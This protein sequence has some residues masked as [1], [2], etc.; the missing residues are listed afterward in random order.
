[1]AD[2]KSCHCNCASCEHCARH[3]KLG[4]AA[5]GLIATAAAGAAL[6]VYVIRPWHLRWQPTPD[7]AAGPMQ[8]DNLVADPT[9]TLTRAITI[10]A[11]P[12]A[13]WPW[14]VQMGYRRA[15]WYS[16]DLF[17][18]DNVHVHRILPEFQNLKVGDVMRTDAEGG[19]RVEAIDPGRAIVAMIHGQE[20]RTPAD[21][22]ICLMLRPLDLGGQRTRLTLRLH[23]RFWGASGL[24]FGLV[25]D[26]GDFVFMRKM[27]L[28]IKQRAEAAYRSQVMA[29]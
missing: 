26:F 14:L 16:Y 2:C 19:F 20:M 8:G 7:E 4:A 11:P 10:E 5:A 23:G 6:Y 22:A 28:G 27:L 13:V 3:K 12:A 1:M 25:F 17:D 15:G 21:I 18:N 24:L 9:I 29:R